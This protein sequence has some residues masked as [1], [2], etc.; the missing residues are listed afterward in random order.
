[1][2]LD[3]ELLSRP[4][5][6]E[7]VK[8]RE[9]RWGEVLDYVE[10]APVISRLNEAFEGHWSFRIVW[11]RDP[12]FYLEQERDLKEVVVLGELSAAGE[13]KQ[14]FGRSSVTREKETGR[15]LSIGDDLKAAASD[16]LKKCAT[17]FGVALYLYEEEERPPRASRSQR[18]EILRLCKVAGL[19]D[20][21]LKAGLKKLFGKSSLEELSQEEASE[22]VE[23]LKKL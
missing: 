5:P 15:V 9:G 18:D 21:E 17:L 16:A 14:Q 2:K 3:L 23:R 8:Q 6:P 13:R 10:V 12:S 7:K 4:F 1:M 11:P 22:V 19:S 20:E